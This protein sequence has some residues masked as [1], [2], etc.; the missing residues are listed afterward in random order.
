MCI[1]AMDG[2]ACRGGGRGCRGDSSGYGGRTFGVDLSGRDGKK[3]QVVVQ[4]MCSRPFGH[5]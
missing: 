2:G 4:Q 3:R 5:G 1:G